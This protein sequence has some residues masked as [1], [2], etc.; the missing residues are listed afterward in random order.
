ML[1]Y[2]LLLMDFLSFRNGMLFTPG[3]WGLTPT[4]VPHVL[5]N[6]IMSTRRSEFKGHHRVFPGLGC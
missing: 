5:A 4:L 3:I 2:F 6:S 1:C